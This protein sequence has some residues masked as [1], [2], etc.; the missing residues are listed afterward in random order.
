MLAA[1]ELRAN[2][3]DTRPDS[4]KIAT[5]NPQAN[6]VLILVVEEERKPTSDEHLYSRYFS[7]VT[8]FV[9]SNPLN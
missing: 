2:L 8:S 7:S 3:L 6:A 9:H 4:I 1:K 5:E